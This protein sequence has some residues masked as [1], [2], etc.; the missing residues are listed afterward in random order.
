MLD[1]I[2]SAFIQLLLFMLI[3]FVWWV[4]TSK[5]KVHFFEWIGLKKIQTS[6]YIRLLSFWIFILLGFSL[7]A[8]LFIP[9]V[10]S[11]KDSATTSQFYGK[12]VKVL[13]MALLYSYIQMG[14]AEEIFFRGFLAKRFIHKFNF[15]LGNILQGFIFGLLHGILTYQT[16]GLVKAIIIVIITG[17]IGWFEGYLNEKQSGG[18]ILSSW[19]LHGTTNLLAALSVMFR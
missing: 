11:A 19:M 8:F 7:V 14:L 10:I 13:P 18:S 9:F 6:S 5:E 12:G 15:K 4:I 3:P 17:T 16:I 2:L 1:N